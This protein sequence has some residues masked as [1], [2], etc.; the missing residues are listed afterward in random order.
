MPQPKRG[1]TLGSNPT[2]QKLML[3]N[4]AESLFEHERIKTTEAKAKALRPYAERLITKAKKGSI[5]H[6]RQVASDIENRT[7]VHKLFDDIG[8]RFA[9]RNGGYTRVLKLGQR[10]GDGA[11]MALIEL[12]EG[13]KVT[14]SETT[15]ASR[16]RRGLRRSRRRDEPATPAASEEMDESAPAEDEEPS[17]EEE[18]VDGGADID[19]AGEPVA[20]AQEPEATEASSADEDEEK[21]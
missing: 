10:N 17:V 15:D 18:T 3:R 12:V 21:N 14:T 2:H 4:L 20:S 7:I 9:D 5:H 1:Y 19:D 6:R 11:R 16:R 8:P 13:A